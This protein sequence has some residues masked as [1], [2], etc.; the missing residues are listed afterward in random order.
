M[1]R[2]QPSYTIQTTFKLSNEW[3]II[4]LT[5]ERRVCGYYLS[6][7]NHDAAA[8]Y[9]RIK[10]GHYTCKIMPNV[11]FCGVPTVIMTAFKMYCMKDKLKV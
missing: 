9:F 3:S 2:V 5:Y 1:I 8:C 10:D 7:D 11:C 4:S 6:H